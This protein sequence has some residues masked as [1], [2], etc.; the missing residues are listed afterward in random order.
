VREVVEAF[1]ARFAG[2]P[3]WVR[4]PA[5]Q[6]PEAQALTLSSELAAQTLSWR[7]T[8]DIRQSLSWTADWYSAYSAGE[9][10]LAFSKAQIA[11]YRDLMI[12]PS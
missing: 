4:D 9:N 12:P 3:G 6:P 5:P 1:G 11:Q 2:R 8:L 10:M 7:P